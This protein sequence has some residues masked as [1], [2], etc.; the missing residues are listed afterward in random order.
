MIKLDV[1]ITHDCWS[2]EE[3]ER[4]VQDVSAKIPEVDVEFFDMEKTVN[5]PDNVFAVPTYL[6]NGKVISLGNPTREELY[7][8]IAALQGSTKMPYLNGKKEFE[9]ETG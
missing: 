7:Q 6:L 4:I 3:S 9:R 5:K 1:Y 8:K 2:C